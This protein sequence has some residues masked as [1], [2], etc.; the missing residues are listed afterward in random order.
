[1]LIL[2]IGPS[3]RPEH[4]SPSSRLLSL[5]RWLKSPSCYSFRHLS[6]VSLPFKVFVG[7]DMKKWSNLAS[8]SSL[9]ERQMR[10]PRL[11][12]CMEAAPGPFAIYRRKFGTI[13]SLLSLVGHLS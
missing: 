1:M 4:F 10:L 13:V 9:N 8:E 5:L 6:T 2:R 3:E 11:A 12:R 7:V